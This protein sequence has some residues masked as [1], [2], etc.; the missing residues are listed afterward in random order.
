MIYFFFG[1]NVLVKKKK[2]ANLLPQSFLVLG[3]PDLGPLDQHLAVHLAWISRC[4]GPMKMTQTHFILNG[5]LTSLFFGCLRISLPILTSNPNHFFFLPK[6][7]FLE[8]KIE[9]S[10]VLGRII[11]TVGH[12]KCSSQKNKIK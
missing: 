2:T 9:L 3:R 8:M 11:C 12:K 1:C 6:R 10:S 7:R 4:F 5:L